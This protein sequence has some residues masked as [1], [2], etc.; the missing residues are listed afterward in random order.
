MILSLQGC[1]AAG[2][3]TA[4]RYLQQHATEIHVSF[5][6]NAAVVQKVKERGLKKDVYEDYLEI[7]R[8]Y[9]LH[10]IQRHERVSRYSNVVMDFGAEEIEF[11]TLDYPKAMGKTWEISGPLKRE[12]AMLRECMPDKILF[13]EAEEKILRQRKEKDGTRSR[14]FF[15]FYVQSL[16][17]LK[18]EWF[19][20]REDVVFLDTSHLT[21]QETGEQVKA[22]VGK[23]F[24][25]V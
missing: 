9:I 22:L 10:E 17:P 16:L 18:R 1:M 21:S 15:D 2:K 14:R 3:T 4:A 13:L 7:Q 5:E 12:L 8:L 25:G 23:I 24:A 11:Y 6:D 19:R 20:G